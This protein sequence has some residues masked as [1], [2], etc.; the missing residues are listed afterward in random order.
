MKSLKKLR[1]DKKITF[2]F[3]EN[4]IDISQSDLCNIESGKQVPDR[5]TR[6]KLEK[7]FAQKIN[8]LDTKYINTEP[9]RESQWNECEREFRWIL[10][11]IAGMPADEQSEFI[12][13]A[14]KQLRTLKYNL[15]DN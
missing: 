10:R 2:Q 5:M 3:I 7:F 11:L 4:E 13:A 1:R 12:K 9:R 14:G 15:S 8:W 6:L